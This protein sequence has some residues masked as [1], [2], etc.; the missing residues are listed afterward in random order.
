[1]ITKKYIHC[2]TAAILIVTMMVNP[3]HAITFVD[4]VNLIQNT[5]SA[6][7]EI[8]AE[9]SAA[10]TLIEQINAAKNLA[11]STSSLKDLRGLAGVDKA[12]LLYR[13][14]VEIDGRLDKILDEG[15]KFAQDLRAKY[16]A[17]NMSWDQFASTRSQM[18]TMQQQASRERYAAVARSLEE[19]T[20][21]RQEIVSQLSTVEGQTQ[22]MQALGA[23]LDVIIGQNQQMIANTVAASKEQEAKAAPDQSQQQWAENQRALYQQRVREAANKF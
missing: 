2:V 19:T 21:R 4:P 18:E 5:L 22:A 3:A 8:Q 17:S 10:R 11:R 15:G 12:Q 9:I 14:L 7:A 6:R 1:M 20:R 13:R 16:G 23:A